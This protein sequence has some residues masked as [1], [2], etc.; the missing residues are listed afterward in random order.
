MA[1]PDEQL[2]DRKPIDIFDPDIP[3]PPADDVPTMAGPEMTWDETRKKW[4]PVSQAQ[5]PRED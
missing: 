4:V 3:V 5:I 2:P 1:N